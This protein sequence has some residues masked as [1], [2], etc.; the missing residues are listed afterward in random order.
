MTQV[1]KWNLEEKNRGAKVPEGNGG[2][3]H[4]TNAEKKGGYGRC[5]F[6][7]SGIL[8][9]CFPVVGEGFARGSE[10]A[11][12]LISSTCSEAKL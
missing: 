11:L 12:Q 6:F 3:E 9:V 2:K 4:L 7:L 5:V 10:E 1:S 8:S